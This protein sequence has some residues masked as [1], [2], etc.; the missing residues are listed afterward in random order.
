MIVALLLQASPTPCT[1][2]PRPTEPPSLIVQ[3]V[4]PLWLPLP[5]M[6]VTITPRGGRGAKSAANTGKDGYA[7]F[8]LAREAEYSVEVKSPGFKRKHLR[9]LQ[10][11]KSSEASPTAFVQF[12]LELSGPF[13]TVE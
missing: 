4:D 5:G 9:S 11:T 1:P 10:I 12:K 8:W 6:E 13:V 7:E 3:T 2:T